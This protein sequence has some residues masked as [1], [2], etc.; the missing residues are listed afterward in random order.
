MA[1]HPTDSRAGRTPVT[2]TGDPPPSLAPDPT[3]SHASGRPVARLQPAGMGGVS[4]GPADVEAR[5]AAIEGALQRLEAGTYWTCEACG[6]PLEEADLEA[7][8]AASRCRD[9]AGD[10][11]TGIADQRSAGDES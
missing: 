8:P 11:T 3:A 6:A 7:D 9:H 1:P 2:A 4:G 5:L 10:S